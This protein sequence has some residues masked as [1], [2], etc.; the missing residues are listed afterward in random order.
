MS[1][2]PEIVDT[3]IYFW[4]RYKVI[5]NYTY[6]LD[7]NLNEEVIFNKFS[8]DRRNLIRKAKKDNVE[9][10]RIYD[11][12]IIKDIVLNSFERKKI[13]LDIEFLNNILL[14]FSNS[15]NSVA[16]VAYLN[17]KPSACSFSIYHKDISYYLLGGYNSQNSHPGAGSL[18][19]F[20]SIKYLKKIGVKKF[21]FEGSMLKEIERYFR[22]F[23]GELIPYYTINKAPFIIE[24]GLKLLKRNSF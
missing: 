4:N 21:D 10:R 7:L 5:P 22:E 8:S 19:I 1:L 12:T 15:K 17:N 6:Q 16:F 13:N 9:I 20:E 3:Q 11:M 14:N 18:C 2:P 23:G 24:C